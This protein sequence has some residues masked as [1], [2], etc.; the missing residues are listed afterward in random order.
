VT[1]EPSAPLARYDSIVLRARFRRP[2]DDAYNEGPMQQRVGVLR[3]SAGEFTL[4]F[5]L[6]D[7]VVFA[8][9][10]V[11]SPAS[12][13]IDDNDQQ[14]WE[15]VTTG[16]VGKPLYDALVQKQNDLM[17]RNWEEGL[18]T[19]R[20]MVALYP[21]DPDAGSSL[22]VYE[23]WVL[24]DRIADSLLPGH[25][26]R[27]AA[28]QAAFAEKPDLP[29]RIITG[30]FH[31]AM[32]L[33]DSAAKR[34]WNS[35]LQKS[36][37]NDAETALWEE[38]RLAQQYIKTEKDPRGFYQV[39]ATDPAY[40]REFERVWQRV[41]PTHDHRLG[42]LAQNSLSHA[43]GAKDTVQLRVWAGR[44]HR[45]DPD[46]T[47]GAAWLAKDML[48]YPTLRDTALAWLREGARVLAE[49]P[50]A[51]RP[52]TATLAAQQEANRGRAQPILAELGNALIADGNPAAGL[53]TLRLAASYGWNPEVL[54]RIAQA[55]MARGDTAAALE[56]YARVVVD[57]GTPTPLKDSI[58]ALIPRS[59]G[60]WTVLVKN[61]ANEMRQQVLERAAPRSLAGPLRLMTRSGE[62][63]RL[64][65]V[66]NGK[67]TVVMFWS[68]YCGFS[69]QPL[70][71]LGVLSQHL[72]AQGAQ[73]VTI[74]DQPFS[75]DLDQTLRVWKAGDLSVWY[76][77]RKD[78][79]RA[80][81][82]FATPNYFVLDA[83]G[84]VMFAHSKLE[85]LPRQV[86]ALLPGDRTIP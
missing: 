22:V 4:T 70:H 27:F 49:S 68:P 54:R 37:Q 76:D 9:F 60:N 12:D 6:P 64:A 23:R 18:R 32:Q 80:F 79:Q 56:S 24:G 59:A 1:Y 77:F 51:Y 61:A 44:Y 7:S 55:L 41:E 29:P 15:L 33:D 63:Q 31:F 21:D 67:V 28:F 74:V 8:V 65:D 52:L 10:A 3:R 2:V 53:D 13:I 62:V 38:V 86:T 43:I 26:K 40:F 75:K 46:I 57:P 71:T 50:D 20:A 83:D 35:R 48:P 25:R 36:G 84:R 47:G 30:M 72:S 17:G 5:R 11:E 82:S 39:V 66:V 85:E 73:V 34:F 19:A 42:M 14:L 69:L 81:T 78:A 16:E 58:R 45:L